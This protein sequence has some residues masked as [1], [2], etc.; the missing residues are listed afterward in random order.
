MARP[1]VLYAGPAACGAADDTH[2]QAL[3]YVRRCNSFLFR[4]A[5][6]MHAAAQQHKPGEKPVNYVTKTPI[7]VCKQ[8]TN[9]N[10]R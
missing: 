7:G 10:G 9:V 4:T 6:S 8:Q 3:S 5:Y 2:L 1:F